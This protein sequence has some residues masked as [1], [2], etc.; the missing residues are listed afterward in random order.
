MKLYIYSI[1]YN[2]WIVL[3]FAMRSYGMAPCL[4]LDSIISVQYSEMK[5]GQKH[6]L[7]MN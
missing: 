7:K 4:L 1:L 5:G 6:L 2:I 3:E